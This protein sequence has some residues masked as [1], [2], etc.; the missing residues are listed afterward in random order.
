[1]PVTPASA[2]LITGTPGRP[3]LIFAHTVSLPK[4]VAQAVQAYT[5]TS[6]G[7]SGATKLAAFSSL[8]PIMRRFSFVT[9]GLNSTL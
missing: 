8:G 3:R 6:N 7:S 9:G 5:S 2:G 4:L 1:M